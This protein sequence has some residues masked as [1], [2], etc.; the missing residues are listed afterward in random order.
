[1]QDDYWRGTMQY[2]VALRSAGV[3]VAGAGLEA[4]AHARAV[5]FEGGQ[6]VVQDGP[7]ADTK[8]QLGGLFMIEVP[9][10]TVALQWASRFPQR[11]GLIIEVR[12]HLPGD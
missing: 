6:A 12:P 11:P 1:M 4:P 5:R 9:D 7:F 2:L 3:F 10:M 8:E